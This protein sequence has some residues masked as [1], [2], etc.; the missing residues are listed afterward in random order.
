MVKGGKKGKGKSSGRNT[1]GA[2]EEY[3]M[4]FTPEAN[5]DIHHSAPKFSQMMEELLQ[6]LIIHLPYISVEFEPGC[7]ADEIIDGYNQAVK[8]KF[9]IK[10]SNSNIEAPKKGL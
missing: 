6:P 5:F 7:T 1:E 4:E 3:V 8:H 2:G 10:H 9:S